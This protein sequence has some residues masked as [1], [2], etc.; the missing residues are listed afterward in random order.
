MMM[1][2]IAIDAKNAHRNRCISREDSLRVRGLMRG[3]KKS[4]AREGKALE[5]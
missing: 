5:S 4:L 1:E 2:M 3:E